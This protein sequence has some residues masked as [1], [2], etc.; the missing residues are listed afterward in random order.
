MTSHAHM[1]AQTTDKQRDRIPGVR[2]FAHRGGWDG[3]GRER[4]Q[5]I[6][7]TK[8]QHRGVERAAT[9]K[10]GADGNTEEWSGRQRRRAERTATQKGG[11]G[12]KVDALEREGKTCGAASTKRRE[13]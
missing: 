3:H 6:G 12:H 5:T 2:S 4:L 1:G 10:G 8:L 7:R 11:A 13:T 9:Q